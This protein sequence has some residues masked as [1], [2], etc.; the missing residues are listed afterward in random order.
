MARLPTPGA[1][2]GVWG[3]VL[4]DYLSQVHN[5]TGTLK[6]HVV[7][8]HNLTPELIAKLNTSRDGDPSTM[9]ATGPTGPA[10]ASGPTGATGATGEQG[11]TGAS[12]LQGLMGSTGAIGATGPIGPTGV[13]ATGATGPVG[14][15]GVQGPA[16]ATTIDGISGLQDTVDGK[17]DVNHTH[18]F[19]AISE[20]TVVS[21]VNGQTLVYNSSTNQWVNQTITGGIDLPDQ[22]GHAGEFLQTD[23]ANLSWTAVSGND[24]DTGGQANDILALT[25]MEVA[26]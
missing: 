17:A 25:W 11:H 13:G 9:G 2:S 21:P 18:S 14:A 1:D 10:G 23:G 8:E 22:L 20:V 19:E 24:G 7:A 3:D 6:D 4:N 16:G 15:T 12:G 5:S 26:S